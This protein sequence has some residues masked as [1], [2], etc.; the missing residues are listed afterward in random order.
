MAIA[1][2][3]KKFI[4]VEIPILG[5]KTH[6]LGYEI[7]DLNGKYITQDLSRIL[8]GKIA[9]MRGLV[10][11]EGE[12]ATVKP[13][14]IK[15]LQT[16]IKRVTRKGTDYAEDS[17]EIT[18]KDAQI[19]VK[20]LLVTRKRVTKKVLKALRE[21]AREWLKEHL[22][23]KDS[24]TI[25]KELLKNKL[26]KEL[27]LILKKIYPLSFCDIRQIKVEKFLEKSEGKTEES[28][29]ESSEETSKEGKKEKAG[30]ETEKKTEKEE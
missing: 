17:F 3:R 6:L 30:K 19:R 13:T 5:R 12:K 27:S 29:K 10:I 18:T 24:E 1:K 26:Q 25:F 20:P 22:S 15:L 28:E 16:F 11:V 2:K 9:E 23:K 7:S 4:E 8:K 14:Q 21:K